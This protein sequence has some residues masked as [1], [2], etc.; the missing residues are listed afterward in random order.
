MV[1]SR[2]EE[3]KGE[4]A[5]G[6]VALTGAKRARLAQA[7]APAQ[8]HGQTTA[9]VPAYLPSNR[10]S[11]STSPAAAAAGAVGSTRELVERVLGFLTG[12]SRGARGDVGR[13]AAVC[14]LWRDVA[15][16]EE[17][18]GRMATEVLPLL[19]GRRDGRRYVAEQG[20]CLVE[21]RVWR[22]DQWWEGLR[23]HLEVWDA[24][25]D[26]RILSAEGRLSVRHNDDGFLT[27]RITGSD[28]REVVGPAF[29]AASRD[30]EHH[31]SFDMIDFLQGAHPP[32]LPSAVCLRAVVSD[33]RTGRQALLFESGKELRLL[34]RATDPD[35]DEM[36]ADS[37]AGS[38]T[39]GTPEECGVL[40]RAWG[41]RYEALGV[42]VGFFLRPRTGAGRRRPRGQALPCGGGRCGA[43]CGP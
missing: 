30:P 37:P 29:S 18:W 3:P 36:V 41:D 38:I 23:L 4:E 15:Y 10:T 28:R 31:R 14:R 39:F 35:R 20:R 2:E 43:L 26:L 9:L 40:S 42:D 27:L 6:G 33:A 12:G 13:A 16:G 32:D 19:G 22:A 5:A 17:V 21:R 7:A 25:D 24:H 11:T 1:T 8:D 34:A